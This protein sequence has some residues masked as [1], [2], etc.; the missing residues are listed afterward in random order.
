VKKQRELSGD[1]TIVAANELPVTLPDSV[2]LSFRL[3][4]AVFPA[5]QL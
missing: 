4:Q 2:P 1:I 5:S 3:R